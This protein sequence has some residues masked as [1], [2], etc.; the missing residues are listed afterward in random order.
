M[1][2]SASWRSVTP[3]LSGKMQMHAAA[4]AIGQRHE[5]ARRL[6]LRKRPQAFGL[7]AKRDVLQL[8]GRQDEEHAA[9]RASLVQLPRRMQVAR[10]HFQAGYHAALIGHAVANRLKRLASALAGER[11]KTR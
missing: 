8:V 6:G 1:I 4:T 2:A 7:L 9:V 10:P 5:V 3:E 11:Q